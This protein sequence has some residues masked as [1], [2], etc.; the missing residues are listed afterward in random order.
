MIPLRQTLEPQTYPIVTRSLL[1]VIVVMFLSQLFSGSYGEI[2]VTVFGF[3]PARFFYPSQFGYLGVESVATLITSLFL[4]GGLLHLGGNLLY[5]SIFGGAVEHRLGRARYLLFFVA[6]GA[7][8]SITHAFVFPLSEIP[9]IGASGSIAAILGCSLCL[10]PFARV[11]TL[12]PVV[13]SW[14]IAEVPALV[15]LPIWFALQFSSGWLS[16]A[17]AQGTEE[18]AGV[19]W[20]AH[21]GGFVF[22]VLVG[23]LLGRGSPANG[24]RGEESEAG[25]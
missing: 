4:H 15:F 24:V 9:S 17:S 20:W 14:A 11:V 21:V 19:A 6:G 18:V 22:G 13:I 23:L 16:L 2:L 8:G 7:A 12:F 25:R 3:I 5:L 1:A 10:Q